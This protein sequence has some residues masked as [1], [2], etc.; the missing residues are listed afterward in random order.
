[1]NKRAKNHA[2]LP[3]KH[4]AIDLDAIQK[5]LE[6]RGIDKETLEK[7]R[8]RSMTRDN[9]VTTGGRGRSLS[10]VSRSKTNSFERARSVSEKRVVEERDAHPISE[11]SILGKRKRTLSTRNRSQSATD[12]LSGIVDAK[13][14]VAAIKL[15]HKKQRLLALQAKRGEADR[16]I[17]TLR[18]KH[19]FSGK[20][21]IGK[22][23]RR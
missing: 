12:K 20:R 19:L 13:Q 9:S 4:K 11:K 7:V 16:K 14:Q 1:L 15:G 2:I 10:T 21:G 23:D 17:P 18:P 3:R 22:T 8:S 5:E 6:S